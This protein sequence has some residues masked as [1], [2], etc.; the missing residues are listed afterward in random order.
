MSHIGCGGVWLNVRR[1]GWQR[2]SLVLC[3]LGLLGWTS[4]LRAVNWL[5][6]GPDGGD[7]RRIAPDPK[8]PAHLFLGTTNGWIYESHN[9]GET[10]H[11]LARVDRRDD[12]VLDAI[13]VDSTNSRHLIVGAHNVDRVDGG[14]FISYDAGKTWINQAEMRGQSVRAL[15]QSPSNP[16]ELVAGTLK[17][18]YRSLDG[19]QRWSLISPRDSTELH[20]FVSVAIDPVDPDIIYA[21]TWHLPW[22]TTDGGQNWENIKEGIIED[23]DV[24]S[25]IVDP[26]SPKVVYA[27]ACSGIYKSDDAGTLFHKVQ[28]IPSSARRTRVLQEDPNDLNI[29]FAGTTEGLFRSND[30]GK[31]WARTTG[32]EVIV[33]DVEV[34]KADSK[35][36]LIATD[37]GGI[38][39]SEDGGDTFHPSNNGFSS[40]QIAAIKRDEFHPAVVLVGIV[41]DKEWGGVFRSDNGGLSWV[42]RSE[43]LQGLDVFALGQAPDGTFIAGTSHG[44]FR[45][46]A[47]SQTWIKVGDSPGATDATNGLRPPAYTLERTAA[48]RPAAPAHRRTVAHRPVLTRKMTPAQRR[49]TLLAARRREAAPKK[50]AAATHVR[51]QS[52]T[53]HLAPELTASVP[54]PASRPIVLPS[55]EAPPAANAAAVLPTEVAP[56]S[57]TS[58]GFDGAVYTLATVGETMLATT[59]A[60]LMTSSDDGLTW[61]LTGP[62]NSTDWR[63]LAA[64]KDNVVAASLHN[65]SFSADDGKTWAPILLPEGL[66]Q[67]GAVAVEPSGEVWVGGREGVFVS[68]DAGNT[69][70]TPENLFVNSVNSLYYD[71]DENRIMVT[72]GG[73]SS[74][75]FLVQLPTMK[76]SFADTGWNLRFARPMGDHLIAATLFDGIVVQPRMMASPVEPAAAEGR[77]APRPVSNINPPPPSR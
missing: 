63:F 3:C 10:W 29:V 14:M 30:A 9:T 38:L 31:T 18:V 68:H 8:D 46:D 17:G 16:K 64:A 23:S 39:S 53:L 19:G 26:V 21:G 44:I 15:E 48:P 74:F 27:S 42:Q 41:N 70:K 33:N 2:V 60:G 67:V 43:G 77:N 56:A 32:P 37:R 35:H 36:V 55:G 4:P 62:E 6:F 28:G 54:A 57:A 13:V 20:N 45:L 40:R 5:P 72:T 51:P 12:L 66:T 7:A 59:S 1:I 34:D 11:R 69:W 75:V 52:R 71:P 24:F 49:A 47:A 50:R 58:R 76:V 73:Y 65:L 25:I 22:K 61:T